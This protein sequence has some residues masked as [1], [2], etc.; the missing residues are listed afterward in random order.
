M[1][2]GVIF[3]SVTKSDMQN[4]K[5]LNPSG[6]MMEKF[7]SLVTPIFVQLNNLAKKNENLREQRDLLLP[8]LI[9]GKIDV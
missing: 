5:L 2:N 6:N 9:S 3:N 8:R 4:I 1:G 7:E